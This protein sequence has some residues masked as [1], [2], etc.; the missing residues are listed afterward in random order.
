MNT[1]DPATRQY[2]FRGDT[3]DDVMRTVIEEVQCRGVDITPSRG[4]AVELTGVL[5]EL[6]NPRAR[7]SRTETRGKLFSGLGELCWYL[8]KSNAVDFIAYY[9]PHYRDEAEGDVIHGGYGPRLFDFKGQDQVANVIDLLA[10]HP[11][12][13]RAVIQLFDAFDLAQ[14][15][16]DVP[17]TCSLQFLA[18]AGALHMFTAM[19]SNDAFLGLPHDVFCFTMIQELVA[20]TLGL[21]LGVYKHAVGSLHLY[22]QHQDDATAFIAEGWQPTDRPM[23]AMPPGDPWPAVKVLLAFEA[24]IRAGQHPDADTLLTLDPY[25]SDLVRLLQVFAYSR[26]RDAERIRGLQAQMSSDVFNA[27]IAPRIGL[28]SS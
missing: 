28:G 27:F 7:L 8:A 6:S 5:L 2:Y 10:R 1:S 16:K 24:E 21:E 25:W 17:C 19:R 4:Q 3:L 15:H 13:R 12:S 14:S 26:Q 23:P 20:R 11:F 18:R 9:L 22:A